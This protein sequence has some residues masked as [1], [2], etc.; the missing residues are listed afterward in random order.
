MWLFTEHVLTKYI[1]HSYPPSYSENIII[2]RPDTNHERKEDVSS[3][4][5]ETAA[6]S[7]SPLEAVEMESL[8]VAELRSRLKEKGKA[9]R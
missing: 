5:L 2:S 1:L 6:M 4:V 9:V 8:T 3:I 7:S